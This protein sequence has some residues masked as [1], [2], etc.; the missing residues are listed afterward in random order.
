[1]ECVTPILEAS[2]HTSSKNTS[3]YNVKINE[4][5]ICIIKT[6]KSGIKT[7]IIFINDV[8]GCRCTRKRRKLNEK[9]ECHPNNTTVLSFFD[10]D[11][12]ANDTSAYLHIYTYILKDFM[13]G[14]GKKREQFKITLRFRLFSRYEDNLK[15]AMKWKNV[16]RQLVAKTQCKSILS[17]SFKSNGKVNEDDKQ[18]G[19]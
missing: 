11:V 17:R 16:I 18:P 14:S 7:K 4:K 9:C 10:N 3:S 8:I 15:E 19:E 5:C 2:F 1:M 12:D 6:Q 13:I